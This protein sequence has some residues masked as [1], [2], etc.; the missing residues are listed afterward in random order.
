MIYHYTDRATACAIVASGVIRPAIVAVYDTAFGAFTGPPTRLDP[1]IWFT[2]AA[3]PSATVLT[4][5]LV[6]G[7]TV[8]QPGAIWRFGVAP[9]TAPDDLEAWA[10]DRGY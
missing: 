5:L 4:R 2:V 3:T 7:V 1:A 9:E 10:A 8:R 6:D